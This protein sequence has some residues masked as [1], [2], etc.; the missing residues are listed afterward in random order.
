MSVIRGI[1]GWVK[2]R[3]FKPKEIEPPEL[4]REGYE[5]SMPQSYPPPY[6]Y[7]Q[8]YP[9]QFA[10]PPAYEEPPRMELILRDLETIK[11][12]LETI[13]ER[14]DKIEEMLRIRRF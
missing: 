3:I 6:A 5:E 1:G 12:N 10:P 2:R 13:N 4:S 9:P 7:P 8:R 14:L 11:A